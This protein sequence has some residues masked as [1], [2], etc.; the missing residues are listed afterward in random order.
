M[1]F[2]ALS[3]PKKQRRRMRLGGGVFFEF[4][5]TVGFLSARFTEFVP[6]SVEVKGRVDR[7]DWQDVEPC[8]LLDTKLF[9]RIPFANEIN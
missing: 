9:I 8:V 5:F 3:F 4:G 1:C 7:N 2:F 6:N